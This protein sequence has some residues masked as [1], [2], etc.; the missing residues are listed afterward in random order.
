MCWNRSSKGGNCQIGK[1]QIL[2]F[3]S[4]I[5]NIKFH[6]VIKVKLNFFANFAK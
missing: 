6:V 1:Y 3:N 4:L 5:D 2:Y